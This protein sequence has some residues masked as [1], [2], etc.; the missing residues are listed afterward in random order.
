MQVATLLTVIGEEARE[1]F[2]TF[3]GWATDGDESKIGPVLAK[4]EQYCQ[5][6]KHV[7]FERYRFNRRM[8]NAGETYDQY[9]TALRKLAEN[10]DFQTITPDDI[11]RDKLVFGI[12]DEK[13][14][15][16]LLRESRL[17]L[18]RTDEI[19]H[20]AES[21]TL[22]MKVVQESHAATVSALA[23]GQEDKSLEV[24]SVPKRTRECWN[25]GR[26]H[27]FQNKE[28]CPAYG[29]VCRKCL[30]PN[31][32]AAKC[33]SRR[34]T[35]VKAVEDAGCRDSDEETFP[36]EA[37]AATLDDTQF[38]TLRVESGS[39]IRFQVDTGAQCNVVPIEIYK[40]ATR[41]MALNQV[42][43]TNTRITAYGGTTLPVVGTVL[44]RVW[45]GNYRC[46]LDC[47][48]V[49][50]P[51]IRPL[52]GRK[53]CIGMNIVAY[54][55]NDQLNKPCTGEA[56][57]YMV[58]KSG[59][60][61]TN[62]LLKEHH[63][64]F[65]DGVGLLQGK[66]HIRLEAGV[67]P[68]QHA[69]RRVPVPLREVLQKSL[70]DLTKQD[71]IAPVQQPTPWVS[72]M[73]I[74]PKKNGTLRICLDPQ[75]LNRAILREHYPL[76]TIEDVATRL[77]GAKVF[78]VLDV[79][80]GFWHVELD[81][82]SSI[83]TTF[84]TPFGRY[85]WKRMPFGI[86][87]APEVFQRRMH[88]LIEGLKGVEVIAD[89]FVVVGFGCS[90][91]KAVKDHDHNLESFLMRCAAR[92]VKL[93][94]EK[95][96][97]RM[98]EVPF[99]GHVATDR[100][101]CVDPA[102]VRAITDM[103]K[104]T[105]VAA[106]QRLLGMTQYLGKFLP[107]LS[108]I[109]KPLRD[110]TQKD[111]EWAWDQ[112]QQMAF[113][114]L[115]KAVAS[116]PVLRYY[117]LDEEVTLQ[118]DASQFGLGATLLQNEQPVAYASR[119]LTSAETR[120]AQIE[121][122]LLAI[123]FACQ[124]FES[125][126]Y[127]RKLVHIETDHQPLEMIAKKPLNTAPKRLQR[128]LLQ[129]QKYCLALKY[130]KGQHMYLADTLSRAFPPDA[131]VCA[132]AQD[133]EEVDH[134]LSLALPADRIQ[135]LKHGSTDD[136]VLQE[137]RKLIW[138]GWPDSKSEVPD[139]LHAYFD[140]RDELTAQEQLI[141]KG[142]AV[143]IPAALRK[144]MMAA[145]H[146]THIGVEGCIRRARESM[147]WPRMSTELK[148]YVAKCDVCMSYRAMPGKETLLSHEFVARPWAKVGA[149]LCDFKGRTLLVV[150]DY[151]SNFIEVESLQ[152]VTSRGVCKAL[153]I[154]F[155]RYGSPD[156]LVTDNGPQFAAAEFATFASSWS[157]NHITSSPRYPQ[158]NGK[159]EN[160]VKTIKRLF[161]KCREVGQSEYKAL[162]DWRNTPSEGMGTSPAQRFFGRRC[163][164]LLPMTQALLEPKYSTAEDAQALKGQ[165]ARQQ[166]YYN[167]QARDLPP[168]SPGDT[169]RMRPPGQS[170]WEK[171]VCTG[172]YGP[173]SYRVKVGEAE[174]RRNRRQLI[175]TSE[176]S[177][178]LIPEHDPE[179]ETPTT[180]S[181]PP[182]SSGTSGQDH[183][184]PPQEEPPRPASAGVP[185]RRS[186]RTRKPPDWITNYVPM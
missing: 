85:R 32:F 94:A 73:V 111:T 24:S 33:R 19:C 70:D 37:L 119:A 1:V 107:H 105:D 38:V 90:L 117:N 159:A 15:E 2:S 87:S 145:C 9:R 71:I 142:P 77:H 55:D 42:I 80:K 84:N 54:L 23:S 78:T 97:L 22:Q 99:I 132:M 29:K 72:S 56:P 177:E 60:L 47:K 108:D 7:P 82:P 17:T 156:T 149:D 67:T 123:V 39:H 144:E 51:D 5:P 183:H 57:V 174:Y 34:T 50:Q 135:Q 46:R 91:D 168:I 150:C 133:L 13:T 178:A 113:D 36:L 186:G 61:S 30:K 115:K 180:G 139:I 45:R 176:T 53:A 184:V 58:E 179:E 148:E 146:S 131:Q 81:E 141:F 27:E 140:F 151:F 76:P 10:C 41:D 128:M 181:D 74:V 173:R 3:S 14:R 44:L 138:H 66:Y 152:S 129:L 130:K 161:S 43:P 21:M 167:R 95:L 118:C 83:L 63:R 172:L 89:D 165:K 6:R 101:L 182:S 143:V 166:H 154:M 4:F 122:E 52:L 100:G 25:C 170:T 102:K 75:D 126:I 175:R 8:Q 103:P 169:I 109:T 147:F 96:K 98:R 121:K 155:A 185:L 164:T 59:P 106:I 127:G 69:P 64:V 92:G 162:L 26:R 93:N 136:P 35:S 171:G 12:R 134:T 16:R 48:L 11:L 163:K 137:L 110:L 114:R 158:S 157:F 49:D 116:T 160:A 153:K 124:H 65:G 62:A 104:P 20:A 120:Y 31:H 125:Y 18:Q 112:P 40:K 68:V 86:C 79:R 28:Q 88:E